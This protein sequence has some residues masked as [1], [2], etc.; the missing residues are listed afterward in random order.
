LIK[1]INNNDFFLIFEI[2]WVIEKNSEQI[3]VLKRK[4]ER[5]KERNRSLKKHIKKKKKNP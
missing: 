2:E 3:K 4:K 1:H 5:K